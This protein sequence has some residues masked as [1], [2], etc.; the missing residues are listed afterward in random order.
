MAERKAKNNMGYTTEFRGIFLINRKVDDETRRILDGLVSTRRV[1]RNVDQAKYGV[2]GEFYFEDDEN[3]IIDYNEP[4][5]TQPG[6]WC[7]WELIGDDDYDGISWDGG[8]KFYNYIEWITYIIE[9][10]IRPRCYS[11]NGKVEWRGEDWE[12]TGTILIEN[13]NITIDE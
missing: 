2:E 12:D 1:K 13:N 4:P 3:G 8:E 7:Q 5:R 11:L 9:S 10:V 6:L